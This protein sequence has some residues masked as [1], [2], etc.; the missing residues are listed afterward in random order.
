MG[1][2][3]KRRKHKVY[4][5]TSSFDGDFFPETKGRG[6]KR[7]IRSFFY[8]F[9][10][11]VLFCGLVMGAVFLLTKS[12]SEN[13]IPRVIG[14]TYAEARKIL[15]LA[16][17]EI[18]VSDNLYIPPNRNINKLVITEQNPKPGP[19]KAD[20]HTVTVWLKTLK[21]I[22]IAK[23]NGTKEGKKNGN[24]VARENGGSKTN[25]SD[26]SQQPQPK[27]TI[28][29]CIDPGHSANSPASEI[30]PET[31]L[32]VADNSGAAGELEAMWELAITTKSMLE[33]LGYRVVLTKESPASYVNLKRRAEIGNSCSVVVRLHY[34]PNLHAILYPGE[35]QYKERGGRRLYVD[36]AVSRA[37]RELA[38]SLFPFLKEVGITRIMN[39]VGGT[40]NNSGP[41]FVGSVLSKVP[42]VLIENNPS[43]VRN[44]PQGRELVARSIVR[45]LEAYFKS[46]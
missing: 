42:V 37:S 7:K 17:L 32:D 6:I 4:S 13:E 22:S 15:E 28:R 19:R 40:S 25:D 36:P 26:R 33:S 11:A 16:D 43:W 44:N 12:P 9:L 10:I 41:A 45:G 8:A 30:D 34:D 5:D 31:G 3:S 29:V 23:K 46:R 27:N 21:P 24:N 1:K 39:D 35:G 20:E 38:N 14:L 2:H 18:V